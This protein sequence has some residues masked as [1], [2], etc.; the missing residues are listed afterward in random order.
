MS[1]DE[2][3]PLP[4]GSLPPIPIPEDT[5]RASLEAL[6]MACFPNV[7]AGDVAEVLIALRDAING[8]ME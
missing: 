1:E 5:A 4:L 7:P 6:K 8:S 3:A 2:E